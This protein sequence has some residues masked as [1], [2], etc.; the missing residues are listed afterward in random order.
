M[1]RMVILISSWRWQKEHP[2]AV[3]LHGSV[4][5]P[6][7]SSSPVLL[8]QESQWHHDGTND[9]K[10]ENDIVICQRRGLL[11]QPPIYHAVRALRCVGCAVSG[12]SHCSGDRADLVPKSLTCCGEM[13]NQITLVLLRT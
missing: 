11:L 2:E 10:D 7:T 4:H 1:L 13:R 5:S 6:W 12:A 3:A 9:G 8:H